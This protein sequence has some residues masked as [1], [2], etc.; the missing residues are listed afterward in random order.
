MK[1]SLGSRTVA[2][3]YNCCL[4]ASLLW[5]FSI[6]LDYLFLSTYFVKCRRTQM[7]LNSEGPYPSSRAKRRNKFCRCWFTLSIK[8]KIRHL[9]VLV[10]QKWQRNAK[11]KA[12]C[13]CKVVALLIKPIVLLKFVVIRWTRMLD[14]KA[15][16]CSQWVLSL[17]SVTSGQE[18]PLLA[19]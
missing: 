1:A 16:G 18:K 13:T 5:I 14:G 19:G 3:A 15:N 9:H 4:N 12:W 8:R 10:V 6:S 7:E 2:Y 11:I 17:R